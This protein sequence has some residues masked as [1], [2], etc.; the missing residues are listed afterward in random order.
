[1]LSVVGTRSVTQAL[2]YLTSPSLMIRNWMK[3][4]SG[5]SGLAVQRQTG[6]PL[7]L[8]AFAA[9]DGMMAVQQ[10]AAA[11]AVDILS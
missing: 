6:D 9:V 3:L 5:E 1:M 8:V 10:V 11:Q 2:R 4:M 7:V